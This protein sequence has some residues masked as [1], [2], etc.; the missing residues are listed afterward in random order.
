[1]TALTDP[2][3]AGDAVA[4]PSTPPATR[5]AGAGIRPGRGAAIVRILFGALWGIDAAFK[6][7]PGFVH[8]QTLSDELGKAAEVNVPIE[9]QWLQLWNS[10][11]LANPPAFA[12]AIAIIETLVAL[13]L[14]TGS[15]TRIAL[16][17]STLLAIGI[18]T[19]AEGMHLPWFKP[20]QTDLGPS[21]GYIFA[22][23]ALLFTAAAQRWSVDEL[24][25]R[26]VPGLRRVLGIPA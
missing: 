1:M 10:V 11:G 6:W 18:W 16:I 5:S 21:V 4:T 3:N 7:M 9:H 12:V 24:L 13:A 22:S 19:G 26:R 23:L 2:A 25:A 14:I 15:F 17:V 8:G 20:G